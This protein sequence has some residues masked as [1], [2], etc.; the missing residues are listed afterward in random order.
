VHISAV[1]K[2]GGKGKE[3][4]FV[5]ETGASGKGK[6]HGEV[7]SYRMK[8]CVQQ[9][10]TLDCGPLVVWI[11]WHLALGHDP[12]LEAP[13]TFDLRVRQTLAIYDNDKMFLDPN[14]IM[15]ENDSDRAS[16]LWDDSGRKKSKLKKRGKDCLHACTFVDWLAISTYSP[17]DSVSQECVTHCLELLEVDDQLELQTVSLYR[18]ILSDIKTQDFRYLNAAK[19][20]NGDLF[21]SQVIPVVLDAHY[22]TVL[23]RYNEHTLL[24]DYQNVYDTVEF[25]GDYVTVFSTLLAFFQKFHSDQIRHARLCKAQEHSKHIGSFDIRDFFF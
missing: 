13:D 23:V 15:P 21:K 19:E 17:G 8:P 7:N 1:N 9:G 22:F 2:T 5:N 18:T 20:F 24:F 16:S 25:Y 10:G 6:V 14:R 12:P 4:H 11:V 3:P